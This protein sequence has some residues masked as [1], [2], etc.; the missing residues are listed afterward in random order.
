LV[1]AHPTGVTEIATGTVTQVD[2]P[3]GTTLVIELVSTAVG[4]S[5]TAKSVVGVERTFRLRADTLDYTLR[6]AA[7]DQPM[8]HHLAASLRRLSAP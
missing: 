5:P 4:L 7:V 3:E 6:M 1:L 8:Q 2:D